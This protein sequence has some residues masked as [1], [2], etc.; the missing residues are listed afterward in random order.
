MIEIVLYGVAGF[1]SAALLALI[2]IPLLRK[3]AA[4]KAVRKYKAN[5]PFST[6]EME[7]R[8]DQLRADHA[9]SLR[10]VEVELDKKKDRVTEQELELR[11]IRE[12][13]DGTSKVAKANKL[14][15]DEMRGKQDDLNEKIRQADSKYA[16]LESRARQVVREKKELENTLKVTKAKLEARS[17]G[18]PEP[19]DPSTPEMS[20]GGLPVA[21]KEMASRLK[22]QDEMNRAEW[23]RMLQEERDRVKEL[24][25]ELEA[26]RDGKTPRKPTS[27]DADVSEKS[28][29]LLFDI[30]AR[31]TRLTA[32][33]EGEDSPVRGMLDKVEDKG[34]NTLSER[35]KRLVDD[36]EANAA[37]AYLAAD[38]D[39][40]AIEAAEEADRALERVVNA[41]S[42][43]Q[44]TSTSALPKTD[45]FVFKKKAKKDPVG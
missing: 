3:Q 11:S 7:A 15:L 39:T 31:I 10:R 35:M 16:S 42:D 37:V 17:K 27:K 38:G 24:E 43:P 26:L 44:N 8:I 40:K 5:L 6:D 28:Q 9:V 36:I 29:A 4:R 1:L 13:L 14:A 23:Q 22:K 19:I 2:T 45:E 12:K 18:E 30:A 20:E 25:T 32:E 21:N 33:V 34:A 41:G